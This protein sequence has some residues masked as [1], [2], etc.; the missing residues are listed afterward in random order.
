ML[1]GPWVI[2]ISSNESIHNYIE[3][4]QGLEILW[5]EID[6]TVQPAHMLVTQIFKHIEDPLFSGPCNSI[7]KWAE[8]KKFFAMHQLRCA[9]TISVNYLGRPRRQLKWR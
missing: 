4:F 6:T 3:R 9:L 1:N 8:S 7:K 5:K 2:N